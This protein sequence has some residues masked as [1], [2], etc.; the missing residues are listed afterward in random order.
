[1]AVKVTIIM[2]TQGLYIV[3]T[4]IGNLEDITLRALSV[5]KEVSVIACEDTRHTALLLHRYEIKNRTVSFHEYN[6]LQRTPEIIDRLKKGEAVALVSDAGTPGISD[7]GYYLIREAIKEGLPVIPIP[8]PS[9]ILAG[10]VVSGLPS[11]HF[12][13][14]GFLPKRE[15]RKIKK[16]KE[17]VAETRT[18]VFYD[19]PFRV[20]RSLESILALF[21]DRRIALARELTK[22]FEEVMRGKISD[23]MDKIKDQRLKGEIVLIVKGYERES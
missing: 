8:G 11:D 3:S 1:M 2:I 15:G 6:K 22:K 20:M 14:E 23:I 4:P 17:L 18:M 19:S 21:G 13:F 10:L 12:V 9:A 5:L 7:P 16:L